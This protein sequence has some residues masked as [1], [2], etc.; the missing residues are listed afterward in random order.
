MLGLG[1]LSIPGFVKLCK[2]VRGD[3]VEKEEMKMLN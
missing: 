1:A 3:K 2:A